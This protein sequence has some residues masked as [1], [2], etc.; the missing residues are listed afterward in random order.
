VDETVKPS[1]AAKP[2]AVAAAAAPAAAVMG[3]AEKRMD[4]ALGFGKKRAALVADP[5]TPTEQT[6]GGKAAARLRELQ[7]LEAREGKL[8][9]NELARM[10]DLR[11]R[12]SDDEAAGGF[13]LELETLEHRLQ[14]GA[15]LNTHEEARIEALR[16]KKFL[17]G[18]DDAAAPAKPSASVSNVA[19]PAAAVMGKAEKRTDVALGFGSKTAALAAKSTPTITLAAA[20]HIPAK[21]HAARLERR[22]AKETP[23]AKPAPAATPTQET[24]GGKAAARLRE[25]EGL[26]ARKGKLNDKDQGRMEELRKMQADDKKKGGFLLELES[27]EHRLQKGKKLTAKEEAR[28]GVLR[29]QKFRLG[30]DEAAVAAGQKPAVVTPPVA[31]PSVVAA[32][33]TEQLDMSAYGKAALM[34]VAKEG[35]KT[36][37]DPKDWDDH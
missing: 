15:K 3:K 18:T 28:V 16:K 9:E 23:A 11:K 7:G 30:V 5:A 27:L 12:K 37:A 19:T 25:L 33:R 36:P 13:L 26:E 29:Q 21:R 10:E 24:K 20:S 32:A 1:A 2:S 17:L 34:L 8:K 35:T 4:V 31:V 6:K 14:D 22:A